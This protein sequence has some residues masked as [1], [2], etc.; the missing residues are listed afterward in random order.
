MDGVMNSRMK[1]SEYWRKNN[2]NQFVFLEA[3]I[4]ILGRTGS[5]CALK[6]YRSP[7]LEITSLSSGCSLFSRLNTL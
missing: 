1:F 2:T 4:F 3:V 7:P 5:I 6:S